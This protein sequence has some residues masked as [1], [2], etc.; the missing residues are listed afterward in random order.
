MNRAEKITF[1]LLVRKY[2]NDASKHG[3]IDFDYSDLLNSFYG[4]VWVKWEKWVFWILM[5]IISE[6]VLLDQR[7][8]KWTSCPQSRV[9][10]EK[11]VFFSVRVEFGQILCFS[12]S[13]SFL[14]HTSQNEFIKY[15]FWKF[16][17]NG[18]N[19]VFVG[20]FLPAD[21]KFIVSF[22]FK[23]FFLLLWG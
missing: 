13:K 7:N 3:N 16:D 5:K 12:C 20:V 6:N 10:F 4:P 22:S 23:H 17:Q 21:R 14:V 2:L 15:A 9:I 1:W 19:K 11:N 8:S 18:L